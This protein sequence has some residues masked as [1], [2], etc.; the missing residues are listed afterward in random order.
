MAR[1]FQCK[2]E[3]FFK[4]IIPDS[5]LVKT[6]LYAIR[7]EFQEKGIP[8]VH[9]F[10]WIFSVP[11]IENKAAYIDFIEIAINAQSSDHLNDPEFFD[12]VKRYQVH[13]HSRTC[14]K[15]NKNECCFSL[16]Y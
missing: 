8:H 7:I 5:P 3:V 12:L 6:K 16:F 10:I 11:N 2:V 13:A 9:S 14:S 4:E 15:Y 1:H